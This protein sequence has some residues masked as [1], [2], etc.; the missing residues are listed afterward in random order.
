MKQGPEV[1]W[2]QWIPT[3]NG[4]FTSNKS[5]DASSYDPAEQLVRWVSET[6][7]FVDG[8]GSAYL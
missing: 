1:I 5:R 7:V 3:I 2:A 4:G 8:S 6:D